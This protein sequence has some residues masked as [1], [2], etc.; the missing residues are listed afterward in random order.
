M[1]W[2]FAVF[3][4]SWYGLGMANIFSVKHIILK[5][6]SV[7]EITGV[8][9]KVIEKENSTTLLLEQA[10]VRG[11]DGLAQK[12]GV[13]FAVQNNE[14]YIKGDTITALTSLEPVPA[15]DN[16]GEFDSSAY[17]AAQNIFYRGFPKEITLVKACDSLY[18]RTIFKL[19]QALKEAY[20]KIA[21]EKEAGICISMVLGDK[22]LLSDELKNLFQD[23]GIAHILAISG[24]HVSLLG[25][26]LYR[27]LRRMGIPFWAGAAVG[28]FL[29][30]AYGVMTGNSVSTIRAVVMFAMTVHAQVLGRTYDCLSALFLSAMCIMVRY[31]Y[32]IYNSGFFL[33][34]GAVLGIVLLSPVLQGILP[35]KNPV[36]DGLFVSMAVSLATLP[37]IMLSY[38]E[39]PIYSVFLNLLV[40]P[41]MGL[42]MTSAVLAGAAGCI[43]EGLGVFFMGPASYV[44]RAYEWLCRL[45]L[46]LPAANYVTGAPKTWQVALYLSIL[47]FLCM[48][49]AWGRKARKAGVIL[50]AAALAV[51]FYRPKRG[52]EVVMLSVGQGDCMYVSC[53]G[54]HIL[55]DGGSTTKKEVGKYTILPFLKYKGVSSLDYVILTH[56]DSDHYSGLCELMQSGGIS[57]HTFVMADIEN[58]P[59]AYTRLYELARQSAER[60][61]TICAGEY[62]IRGRLTVCCIHPQKA[63]PY[64]S[65]NDSSIVLKWTYG[66]FD[67]ITTG[68]VEEAG[69][70]NILD[71]ALAGNVEVLKC[72]HH[73]SVSSSS[74]SWL[75]TVRPAITLISCG[76]NNKYGHPHQ[77]TLEKLD[78]IQSRYYISHETGAVT[79]QTDGRQMAVK[80]LKK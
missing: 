41:M 72:A 69:E 14:A 68:D 21:G 1:L 8:V 57:I 73:G 24:L 76:E 32:C 34:F 80:Y 13:L 63:Y 27:L 40:V 47:L 75:E 18:L 25:L 36:L 61:Q 4:I 10:V 56:P 6:D 7:Y 12:T 46:R 20:Q 52:M 64:G 33:S 23:N 31:P 26:S 60:V 38:Y 17:Y 78:K 49:A 5:T 22:S 44:I 37:V 11:G 19:R 48:M 53:E 15:P 58:P 55:I 43:C 2:I 35:V 29:M 51:L 59:Q 65:I 54:Y 50:I 9:T 42:L 77:E 74:Q 66:D 62:L 30:A 67:M 71:N 70:K 28:T 45:V 3:L 39:I 16:P 79:L